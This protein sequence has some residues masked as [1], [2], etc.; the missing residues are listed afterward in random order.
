LRALPRRRRARN[1][2][3]YAL[4]LAGIALIARS[5]GGGATPAGDLLVLASVV[6]SASFIVLQPRLL[7]GRDPA[8]VTAVQFGAGALVALPLAV[9]MEGPPAVPAQARPALALAAL[10]LAGTL[11]PFWLFAFGQTRVPAHIAGAF[12]NLEP[13]VGAIAGWMAFGDAATPAQ[14]AGALTVLV[15][16]ALSTARARKPPTASRS[17]PLSPRAGGRRAT[18]RRIVSAMP[19]RLGRSHAVLRAALRTPDAIRRA[20]GCEQTTVTRRMLED[21]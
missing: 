4:T 10:S 3:G 18:R 9:M 5:G 6:V 12:V 7:A 15:A 21:L 17:R 16:L 13:V 19:G 14:V 1:G 20:A 8:A 11:L 2:S